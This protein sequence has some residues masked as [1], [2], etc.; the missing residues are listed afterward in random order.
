MN[1]HVDVR[2]VPGIRSDSDMYTLGYSF[3]PWKGQNY[4]LDLLG[5][6]FG[7]VEDGV[8]EFSGGAS[9]RSRAPTGAPTG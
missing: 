8:I 6:R 9:Q 1:D 7:A 3:R 4:L 2:V 5:L